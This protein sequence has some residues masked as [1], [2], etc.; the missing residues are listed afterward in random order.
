MAATIKDVAAAAGVSIK[1]V[2]RVLNNE[3][4]VTPAMAARVF[5]AVQ[6]LN[7]QPDFAARTLRSSRSYLLGLLFGRVGPAF[8]A[9]VQ[10]GASA[11]CR[12]NGYHLV[13]EWLDAPAESVDARL[14]EMLDRVRLGGVILTAPL[15]Y[16]DKLM[17]ALEKRELPFVRIGAGDDFKRS[18]YVEVD[19]TRL[20]YA[21]TRHLLDLGHR[22]IGFI[23]G[24]PDHP[25]S[26][27]RFNGFVSA[28]Q[29]AQQK[30][31][32]AWVKTGKFSYDSALPEAEAMLGA[33]RRPTA[34]FAANDNMA[35]AVLSAA[36]RLKIDVPTQLSVAGCD[37]VPSARMTWPGLTTIR[38][39]MERM[40]AEAVKLL[41]DQTNDDV[42][43]GI[44]L[45]F[46][47]VIR[48]STA[49]PPTN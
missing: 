7:Y 9:A 45:D 2:S 30:V 5:A 23:K 47:L 20:A 39:P 24:P 42:I 31:N 8:S 19:S 11:A 40:A 37:D 13:T 21:M 41:M 25:A 16:S 48:G 46:E 43:K 32:P 4:H 36:H 18:S 33:K 35:L 14:A 28:M 34:I 10:A 15:S 49:A 38:L 6:K 12:A 26:R 44:Q 29:E 17:S 27:D 22:D 3:A 1:T